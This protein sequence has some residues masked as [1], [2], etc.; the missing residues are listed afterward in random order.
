MSLAIDLPPE[1]YLDYFPCIDITT[2]TIRSYMTL[3]ET[4]SG[5][6]AAYWRFLGM[7]KLSP[8][9]DLNLDDLHEEG[10]WD[11][12]PV[13]AV[14]LGYQVFSW[15]ESTLQPKFLLVQEVAPG[16]FARF[17]LWFPCHP[18]ASE[19][20]NRARLEEML[21][22]RKYDTEVVVERRTVHFV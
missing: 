13:V 6:E 19:L 17:R 4:S 20:G 2:W 16:M 15:Q 12:L 7:E 14:C 5:D 21:Q 3:S 18:V 11:G 9:P 10:A 1:Y 22:S 8:D